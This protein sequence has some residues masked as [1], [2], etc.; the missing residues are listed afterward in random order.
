MHIVQAL[1]ALGVGGSELVVA[2]LTGFLRDRGHRVTVL[3]GGGPLAE[4][5]V[6]AGADLLEWPIGRKRLSTLKF[7]RQLGDWL[8]TS[9]PDI[10]HVHSRLPAWI[11]RRAMRRLAPGRRPLFIASMHGQYTVSPYS[12]VMARADRVIAVSDHIREFT[13]A[14]YDFVDPAKLVTIHG[15]TSRADFPHGHRP[16]DDWYSRLY[17]E[18][19][20]LKGRRILLLPGRLSRYKGH[21]TFLELI[22]ALANDYPET[23]GVIVGQIRPGSRY[24]AE[25][26]GLAER[27]GVIDRI[28]FAGLRTDIREWMAAAEIVFNLC[29]DPP[30]AFG[31][32]V[33]EALHLGVPV[34]AWNHG[35][36]REILAAMFPAGAVRP[37]DRRELLART[38]SFLD[39]KPRVPESEDFL[40]ETS[41]ENTLRLYESAM[42]DRA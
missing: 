22:A 40:L 15:G 9:R 24:Q 29:S 35:G 38:I 8:E 42:E 4:R 37:D 30:E 16:V 5:I 25:L 6:A 34:I 2:E 36:V 19:P 33:P 3:G 23:H 31:R 14:N 11:C 21:A 13:L 32:V 20:R 28:T 39:H 12:A 27:G 7:I 18:F 26:E 41:M 1:S 10:V 17:A